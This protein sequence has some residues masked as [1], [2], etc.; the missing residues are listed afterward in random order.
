FLRFDS[1]REKNPPFIENERNEKVQD[2]LEFFHT[3]SVLKGEINENQ[4]RFVIGCHFS[5]FPSA[6]L[7]FC[8]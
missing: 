5:L 6:R 2:F 1:N 8:S 7:G 3:E 4:T